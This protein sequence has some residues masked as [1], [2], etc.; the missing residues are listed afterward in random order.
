VLAAVLA[1]PPKGMVVP[2]AKPMLNLLSGVSGNR[3]ALIVFFTLVGASGSVAKAAVVK[4]V[5]II[6]ATKE[7]FFM[8][9]FNKANI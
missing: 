7:V 3:V 8:L 2:A 4:R 1:Y 6:R 5:L 9:L